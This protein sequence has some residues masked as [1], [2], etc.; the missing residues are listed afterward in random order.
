MA[1]RLYLIT[2]S[3]LTGKETK[4]D[5]ERIV[6]KL[7]ELP[8]DTT[9][10]INAKYEIIKEYGSWSYE[11]ELEREAQPFNVNFGGPFHIQ[12]N[13]HSNIGIIYTIYK[14]RFLY[15]IYNFDLFE[16]FRNDLYNIVKIIKGTEVIYLA[17][18]VCDKLS[19]YLE[20]MA[21]ENVPYEE[22]KQK[23]IQEFGQPV[24]DYSKLNFNKLNYKKITEFFLDD[25]SDLKLKDNIKTNL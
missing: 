9:S 17:D 11:I 15:E 8:M 4:N 6:C 14:Y 16:S 21:W 25:F 3:K 13:L 7:S 22:I 24:T 1:T 12:P 19:T 10:Y 18:D 20:C 23:M 5:W 2:N